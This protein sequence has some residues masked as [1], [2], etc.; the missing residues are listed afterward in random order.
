[1]VDKK[2]VGQD[3]Y[4]FYKLYGKKD[5]KNCVK[6]KFNMTVAAENVIV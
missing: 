1:M 3:D 5:N 2:S 4:F 6:R